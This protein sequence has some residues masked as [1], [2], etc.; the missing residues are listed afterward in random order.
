MTIKRLDKNYSSIGMVLDNS[1]EEES[2]EFC[3]TCAANGVMS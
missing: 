3:S 2:L 1:D